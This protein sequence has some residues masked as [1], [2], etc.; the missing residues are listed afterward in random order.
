M[1][2][3]DFVLRYFALMIQYFCA[4][5]TDLCSDSVVIPSDNALCMQIRSSMIAYTLVAGKTYF[6]VCTG[7]G[8]DEGSFVL[9]ITVPGSAHPVNI[10]FNGFTRYYQVCGY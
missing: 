5:K 1:P 9:S 3:F 6:I 10:D 7:Y 2:R 4:D 8:S